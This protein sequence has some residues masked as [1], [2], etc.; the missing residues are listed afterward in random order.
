M[1]VN[2]VMISATQCAAF[3]GLASKDIVLGVAVEAKHGSLFASYLCNLQ[4]GPTAVRDMIV[5]D[6]RRFREIG[7]LQRAA[8]ILLV[9]RLFLTEYPEARCRRDRNSLRDI[10]AWNVR[11]ASTDG[12]A[13]DASCYAHSTAHGAVL[14][15]LPSRLP[16]GHCRRS[17]PGRSG[18]LV[19]LVPDLRPDRQARRPRLDA[20]PLLSECPSGLE[21]IRP[22]P[23]LHS[24]FSSRKRGPRVFEVR[25]DASL[26]E[27]E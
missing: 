23:P 19:G 15:D 18:L 22:A 5:A 17:R 11:D 9:L 24:G 1:G 6:L 21:G 12:S 25:R 4:R 10:G 13:S 20:H 7:A 3:A 2:R 16:L 8:D 14:V 27:N 26:P